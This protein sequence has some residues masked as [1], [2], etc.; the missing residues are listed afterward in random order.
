MIRRNRKNYR[1]W[2]VT[3]E[4]F[5]PQ[6]ISFH[7]NHGAAQLWMERNLKLK[8]ATVEL[9]VSAEGHKA[10]KFTAT[11]TMFTQKLRRSP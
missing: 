10:R 6:Y 2:L 3:A 7:T 11:T 5:E 8:T 1:V 9:T 4:G